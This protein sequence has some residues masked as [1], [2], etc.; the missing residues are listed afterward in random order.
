MQNDNMFPVLYYFFFFHI[1][2]FSL[3][4]VHSIKGLLT[5]NSCSTQS[6]NDLTVVY[7]TLNESQFLFFSLDHFPQ[8]DRFTCVIRQLRIRSIGNN[9]SACANDLIPFRSETA[10]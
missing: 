7:D 10:F 9:I 2:M 5:C 6:S 1:Q 4:L 3:P 8:S